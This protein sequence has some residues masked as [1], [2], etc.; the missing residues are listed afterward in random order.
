MKKLTLAV[1]LAVST[2]AA[3]AAFACNCAHTQAEKTACTCAGGSS[4][5]CA[6]SAKTDKKDD[7]A[8]PDTAK[9]KG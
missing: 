9:K 8:K 1:A 3:P 2:V 5:G 7:K 4:C 6:P